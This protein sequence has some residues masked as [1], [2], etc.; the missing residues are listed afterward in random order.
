MK[1][2]GLAAGAFLL[3]LFLVA[4]DQI[5]DA[6]GPSIG[7]SREDT[8]DVCV[9]LLTMDADSN[10][11]IHGDTISLD[12]LTSRLKNQTEGASCEV[13]VQADKDVDA[14]DF[15]RL[16]DVVNAATSQE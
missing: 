9:L 8:K 10:I 2:T 6:K 16:L 11:S 7:V 14:D 15:A 3:C 1:R 12:E 5:L 13:I 4:C